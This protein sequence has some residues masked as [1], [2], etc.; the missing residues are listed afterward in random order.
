MLAETGDMCETDE[1]RASVQ[2]RTNNNKF[3]QVGQ[4]GQ[5]VKRLQKGKTQD[6]STL[7]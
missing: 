4:K 1:T 5:P 7:F 6:K 3:H 2:P